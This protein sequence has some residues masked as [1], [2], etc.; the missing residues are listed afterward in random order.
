MSPSTGMGYYFCFLRM[1]LVD[2]FWI[3]PKLKE[4]KKKRKK[5]RP[6]QR[7]DTMVTTAAATNAAARR[8]NRKIASNMPLVLVNAAFIAA[9]KVLAHGA[10]LLRGTIVNTW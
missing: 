2:Y 3:N 5:E 7:S 10:V 6:T 9:A 4:K 1:F 8:R